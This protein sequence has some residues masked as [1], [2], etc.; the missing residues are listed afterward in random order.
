MLIVSVWALNNQITPSVFHADD[1][2]RSCVLLSITSDRRSAIVLASW[3][4][5]AFSSCAKCRPNPLLSMTSNSPVARK[6]PS[7]MVLLTLRCRYRKSVSQ[8]MW[9]S[10][11][12]FS[13]I[14]GYISSA[15]ASFKTKLMP[16][17]SNSKRY[18]K[19]DTSFPA[20][21]FKITSFIVST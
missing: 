19:I 21:F 17:L 1:R 8:Q 5:R 11:F 14:S 3:N 15:I 12:I 13:S 6:F 10:G 16:L 2:F 4:N 9:T 7:I 18:K 20:I